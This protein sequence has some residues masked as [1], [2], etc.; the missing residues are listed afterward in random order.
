VET[1]QSLYEILGVRRGAT[2]D[3]IKRSYRALVKK[4]HPDHY[5]DHPLQELSKVKMQEINEAYEVLSNP[6]KR[7]AYDLTGSVGGQTNARSAY[8]GQ[9]SSSPFGAQGAW[10]QQYN[11]YNRGYRNQGPYNRDPY[12]RSRNTGGC[13]EPLCMLC[14]ADSCCEC[15][16]GDLCTCI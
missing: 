12:Y 4:Y 13:C 16:G 9:T 7:R 6:D 2:D 1:K 10:G 15:L 11:Y 3:E 14:C 5:R 8:G